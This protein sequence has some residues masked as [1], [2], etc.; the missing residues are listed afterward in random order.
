MIKMFIDV[1]EKKHFLN[2]MVNHVSF[3]RR[4][5]FWILNYLANHEAI[6]NNVHFIE[7]ADQ[8]KRG[9]QIRDLS[10]GGEPLKL[11]LQGKEFTDTD[12]IFHEIRLNWKEPLY[13]ECLFEN[14]W[15]NADYMAI[16]EENPFVSW[17]D[18][19]SD[20][21][22]E[23]INQY[24]LEKEYES[25]LNVLYA[26]IDQALE[27]GDRDSFLELSNEVNQRIFEHTLSFDKSR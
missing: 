9:L 23:K 12:Q 25:Q 20:E 15:Q 27:S 18:T 8:S 21:N 10:N 5:V 16:L 26:Q 7:E 14:A 24:F 3:S 4:E 22:K 19:V 13:V 6:L 17:E 2:W 1:E 11:F